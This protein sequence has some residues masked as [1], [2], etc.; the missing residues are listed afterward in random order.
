MSPVRN[1]DHACACFALGNHSVGSQPDGYDLGE[2]LA[3]EV[4]DVSV[5]C[6]QLGR[7]TD[8]LRRDF[9]QMSEECDEMDK[10]CDRL[11][12]HI[13]EDRAA[14]A[15]IQRM[16]DCQTEKIKEVQSLAAQDELEQRELQKQLDALK[17]AQNVALAEQESPFTRFSSYINS[18]RV[19]QALGSLFN[20]LLGR[21]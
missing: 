3:K 12:V 18:F 6:H 20:T 11:A 2:L 16:L 1:S 5:E 17:E 21:I 7:N 4:A 9:A 15:Q 10:E 14:Y 19:I 13:Q 8:A